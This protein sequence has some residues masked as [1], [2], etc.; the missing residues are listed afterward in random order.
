[1]QYIVRGREIACCVVIVA[2]VVHVQSIGSSCVGLVV[3]GIASPE[4]EKGRVVE[5][6]EVVG[7]V[8]VCNEMIYDIHSFLSKPEGKDSKPIPRSL[9]IPS[10][11]VE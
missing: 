10:Q 9:V 8:R 5:V 2:V 1:M 3:I 4:S 11:E 6:E 7:V